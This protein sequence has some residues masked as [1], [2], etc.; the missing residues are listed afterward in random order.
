MHFAEA[1]FECNAR[2]AIDYP[3]FT[4]LPIDRIVKAHILVK[5]LEIIKGL[6]M[7]AN[8]NKENLGILMSLKDKSL[9]I[10]HGKITC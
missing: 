2:L 8:Q 5:E 9:S 1:T 4:A 6:R 3:L 10:M 7:S